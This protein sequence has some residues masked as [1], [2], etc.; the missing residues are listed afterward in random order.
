MSKGGAFKSSVKGLSELRILFAMPL[1]FILPEFQ[2]PW[3]E[4]STLLLWHFYGWKP[5]LRMEEEQRKR[6]PGL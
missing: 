2:T 3:L 1:F 5:G 4:P 6:S